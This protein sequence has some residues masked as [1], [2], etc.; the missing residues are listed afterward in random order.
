MLLERAD[1]LHGLSI[2]TLP[3]AAELGSPLKLYLPPT[4]VEKSGIFSKPSS[5]ASGKQRGWQDTWI[6]HSQLSQ[7]LKKIECSFHCSLERA[8][9]KSSV[10]QM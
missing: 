3:T 1:Q 2:P 9:L 5:Q 6:R 10:P 7:G 8:E 4:S